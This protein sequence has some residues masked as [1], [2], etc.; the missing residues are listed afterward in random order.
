MDSISNEMIFYIG[1]I[2]AAVSLFA[3]IIHIAVY[4]IKKLKLKA[5]LD[6]EYGEK[7]ETE[8]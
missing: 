5:T 2:I 6:S 8:K 4:K 7:I 3:I 1:I